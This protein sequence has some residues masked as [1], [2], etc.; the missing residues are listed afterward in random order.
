[1]F[2]RSD[3]QNLQR[4]F[5]LVPKRSQ[6]H[7][8]K[9]VGTFHL[10]RRVSDEHRACCISVRVFTITD[11]CVGRSFSTCSHD[12]TFG[13]NKILLVW[14]LYIIGT[15]RFEIQPDIFMCLESI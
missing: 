2:T 5:N 8:A 12:P 3:F 4:I 13:T 6:G 9:F 11:L 14:E 1:M 10:S 7:H 15:P